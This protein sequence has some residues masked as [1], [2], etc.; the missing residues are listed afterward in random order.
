MSSQ[1]SRKH[2]VAYLH[3]IDEICKKSKQMDILPETATLRRSSISYNHHQ[4]HNILKCKNIQKLHKYFERNW[5]ISHEII[6]VN[7]TDEKF[8]TT[9]QDKAQLTE[10]KIKK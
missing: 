4:H 2:D 6:T 3:F 8:R 7:N 10:K 1:Q 9:R 5:L